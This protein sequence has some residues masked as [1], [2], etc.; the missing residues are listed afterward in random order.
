V[1][2]RTRRRYGANIRKTNV[3]LTE[4]TFSALERL[5]PGGQRS[6]FIEQA[7]RQALTRQL[8]E[9]GGGDIP[10][11]RLEAMAATL[12]RYSEELHRHAS[13]WGD[14]LDEGL[15]IRELAS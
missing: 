10:G 2:T 12:Q 4:E 7:I 5:V 13:F 8:R 3:G 1:A 15:E 6:E 11:E 14:P 9:S